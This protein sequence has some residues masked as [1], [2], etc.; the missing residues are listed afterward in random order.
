MNWK[1]NTLIVTLMIPVLILA[2][3][4][5]DAVAIHFGGTEASI[6]SLIINAAYNMPF[7]V[8]CIGFSSG[9]LFGHL[10]WR[11]KPNADTIANGID[12]NLK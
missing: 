2:I 5:Y 3:L 7:M 1:N 9:I 6:S 11:M 12:K 8:F 10:F 4:I